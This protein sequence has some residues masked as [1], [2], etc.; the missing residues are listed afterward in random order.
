MNFRILAAFF[1]AFSWGQ[2]YAA[3]GSITISS[4]ANGAMV[5]SK[6]KV[7]V[8]YSAMLGPTGDHL[9]LYVDGKRVDVLREAKGSAD[10]DALPAGKH[11]VC[12]TV[13]TSSHAPTG[14]ETCVDLTSQ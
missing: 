9:H 6:T 11:H 5:S 4:P 3:D 10:L 14:V 1:L 2:S 13:N 12:L 8:A 7:P